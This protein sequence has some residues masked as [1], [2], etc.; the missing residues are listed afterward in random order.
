MYQWSPV[1]YPSLPVPCSS[2]LAAE[3][4]SAWPPSIS[5]PSGISQFWCS[6]SLSR[7]RRPACALTINTCALQR[8]VILS[9]HQPAGG[10]PAEVASLHYQPY[11]GLVHGAALL[12]SV[13][14]GTICVLRAPD[15]AVSYPSSPLLS[16]VLYQSVACPHSLQVG[17]REMR[18]W[19]QS[20]PHCIRWNQAQL[21][22]ACSRHAC[23]LPA[24]NNHCC[25]PRSW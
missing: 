7:E 17:H 19:T 18:C 4:W 9:R 15:A 22:A 10:R 12:C 1:Q 25:S 3:R 8:L 13:A 23:P 2:S 6:H 21:K 16:C 11:S 20:A 5:V 24:S 14:D